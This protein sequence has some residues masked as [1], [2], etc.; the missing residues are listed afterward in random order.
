MSG[1]QG[2]LWGP[3][4]RAWNPRSLSGDHG[5]APGGLDPSNHGS[6]CSVG[7]DSHDDLFSPDGHGDSNDGHDPDPST[8]HPEHDSVPDSE[9]LERHSIARDLPARLTLLL[10]HHADGPGFDLAVCLL[11][12]VGTTVGSY[13]GRIVNTL[14]EAQY[15]QGFVNIA[16]ILGIALVMTAIGGKISNLGSWMLGLVLVAFLAFEGVYY[17]KNKKLFTYGEITPSGG[18]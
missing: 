10:H 2:S 11:D 15:Q 3:A 5:A 9:C 18:S 6:E 13:R 8:V 17:S 4:D 1:E 7:I 12:D 14:S 16:I